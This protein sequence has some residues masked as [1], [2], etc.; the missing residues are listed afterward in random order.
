MKSIIHMPT[1][2]VAMTGLGAAFI[3]VIFF[4][5]YMKVFLNFYKIEERYLNI[6]QILFMV[7]NAIN[8][9]L[10]GWIQDVGCGKR[11]RWVMSRRKVILYMGPLFSASFLLFWFPWTTENPAWMVGLHLLVALFL[12]DT[13]FSLV[14]SAYCGLFT[15]LSTEHSDRVRVVIYMEVSFL[16]GSMIIFPVDKL[17]RNLQDFHVFQYICVA[18]AILSALCFLYSGWFSPGEVAQVQQRLELEKLR[19]EDAV[20]I[21]D[22]EK[23]DSLGKRAQTGLTSSWAIIKERDFLCVVLGN[24]F[25]V[26]RL[27]G[28]ISFMTIFVETLISPSGFLPLESNSLSLF[29]QLCGSLPSIGFILMWPA[30]YK[31]GP[32]IVNSFQGLLACANCVIALFVGRHNPVWLAVFILAENILARAGAIGVYNMFLPAVIEEDMERHNRKKPLSTLI[33]TLNA[34]ITKPAQSFAPMIVVFFLNRA[35]YELFN[36]IKQA[37][38]AQNITS[39][40]V[41][42]INVTS[43]TMMSYPLSTMSPSQYDQLYDSMFLIAC[44]FPLVCAVMEGLL[45]LPYQLKFRHRRQT[46]A[47]E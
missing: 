32:W 22:K 6:A 7:W 24:F 9:P 18:A 10:F 47:A 4:L 11:C 13:M 2:A 3:N 42:Q 30:L 37:E 5:Y 15:E 43:T 12:Y 14:L 40:N 19:G 31:F 34:L 35:H 25:R 36:D 44:L 20:S 23:H 38:R 17:S 46:I 28:S 39:I 27:I 26:M 21:D 8:D 16:L 33:F 41:T 1:L 45:F 29:Y